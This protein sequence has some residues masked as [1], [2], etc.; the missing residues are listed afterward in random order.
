MIFRS[1]A[2]KTLGRPSAD[3]HQEDGPSQPYYAV[4]FDSEAEENQESARSYSAKS[5]VYNKEAHENYIYNFSDTF[6]DKVRYCVQQSIEERYRDVQ[7]L[8]AENRYA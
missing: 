7:V 3:E 1:V 2:R 5:K 4:D 8:N 6:V